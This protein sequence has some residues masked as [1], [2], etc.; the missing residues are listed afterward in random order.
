VHP[1]HDC[2]HL[3]LR[4][5]RLLQGSWDSTLAKVNGLSTMEDLFP[6]VL[7]EGPHLHCML[8]R[9]CLLDCLLNEHGTSWK[10]Q[11]LKLLG[12]EQPMETNGWVIPVVQ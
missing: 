11:D 4:Q 7:I 1:E 12:I 2:P 10:G 5:H 8:G 3:W 9:V 6:T